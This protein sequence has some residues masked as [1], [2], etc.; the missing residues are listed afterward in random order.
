[1]SKDF[2]VAVSCLWLADNLA[3][4]DV[5]VVDGSWFMPGAD[6]NP[7]E[8]YQ[9]EHIIG[10]V[11]FNIDEIADQN[12]G[13][14]HS[15]PS[16]E[17][18]NSRVRKLGLG[19]GNRLVV[20]DRLGLF[21]AARVWWMFKVMGHDDVAILDGGL[22]KWINEG[23]PT[24]DRPAPRRERHFTPR[25]N[26]ILIRDAD[27]VQSILG[28]DDYVIID[29]RSPERFRGEADE[30]RPGLRK[31]HIPGAVNVPFGELLTEDG[32]FKD[33]DILR[34]RFQEAGVAPKK[35]VICYCGSGVTACIIAA[36]LE[37]TGHR[38]WSVYD[39]SWTEWGGRHDLPIEQP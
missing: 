19:D 12:T 38:S 16:L 29:A 1:M 22:P 35:R 7:E 28:R 34:A 32:C 5:R 17:L 33:V 21:S 10:A 39:G 23:R 2:P 31:G 36:A 14:P 37:L 6:L 9:R 11:F 20:Y 25:M 13:L 3:S 30:P 8:E 26:N 24:S 18:F 27:Q 15:F 4:P